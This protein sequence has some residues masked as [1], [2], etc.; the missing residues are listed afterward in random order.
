MQGA[1]VILGRA[2]GKTSP[3]A[4]VPWAE[5]PGAVRAR[6]RAGVSE[7]PPFVGSR[8]SIISKRKERE[9]CK[10]AIGDI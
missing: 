9:G 10:E 4:R 8:F 5:R 2:C 3:A 7:V 6:S 1:G